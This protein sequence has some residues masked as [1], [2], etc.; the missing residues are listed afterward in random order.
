MAWLPIPLL[1]LFSDLLAWIA[2]RVVGYRKKVIFDNLLQAFPEKTEM[3]R[4][5]IA[6]AFYKNLSD[7]L[8]ESVKIFRIQSFDFEKRVNIIGL[9]HINAQIASGKTVLGLAAHQCNWEWNLLANAKHIDFPIYAVYRPLSNPFWDRVMLEVRSS[10]GARL[11]PMKSFFRVLWQNKS[12]CKGI[13]MLSD[14][15]PPWGEIQHWVQFMNRPTAFFTGA[16][17]IAQKLDASVYY[18]EMTR[19]RRGF[20]QVEYIP[21]VISSTSEFPLTDAY[22]QAAEKS[23]RQNPSNWLWSHR[24]WKHQP[25]ESSIV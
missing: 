18:L 7:V 19:L 21:L 13:A 22:A 14:Q 11:F 6:K 4:R 17:K 23:I 12:E 9:D 5:K 1:Y 24:R 3:E 10:T 25:L 2:F 16:E 8:V 15:T 20:Y